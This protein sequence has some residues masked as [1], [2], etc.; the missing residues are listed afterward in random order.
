MDMEFDKPTDFKDFLYS[1]YPQRDWFIKGEQTWNSNIN[2]K[3]YFVEILTRQGIGFN[4][5]LHPL[6]DLLNL[7]L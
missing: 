6:E 7:D 1:Y 2:A 5:N 3:E 4:F